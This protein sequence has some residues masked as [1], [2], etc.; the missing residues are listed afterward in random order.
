VSYDISGSAAPVADAP[1]KRLD[2]QAAGRI[3]AHE[4][5]EAL[6]EAVDFDDV[7]DLNPFKPHCIK[8]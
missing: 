5:V 6:P 2:R 8:A 1:V 4:R 3:P 7:P